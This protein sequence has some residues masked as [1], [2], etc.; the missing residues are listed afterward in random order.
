MRFFQAQCFGDDVG[1]RVEI[2]VAPAASSPWVDPE[3][4]VPGEVS[5][6]RIFAGNNVIK[7]PEAKTFSDMLR[8]IIVGNRTSVGTI[9]CTGQGPEEVRILEHG[10]LQTG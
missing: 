4:I 2:R 8:R 3:A 7:A 10:R 9:G 1:D 5:I 6:E